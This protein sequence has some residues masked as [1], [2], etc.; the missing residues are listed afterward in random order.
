M[1]RTAAQLHAAAGDPLF[2]L[3]AT[4][5]EAVALAYRGEQAEAEA[6]ARR[7]RRD[8]DNIG[9]LSI[10]A[11][12]SYILGETIADVD[13]ATIAYDDSI[14][15]AC[16]ASAS[17]VSGLANTSL[18]AREVRAGRH[19]HARERLRAV[20]ETWLRAGIWNQQWLAIRILIEAL[21]RDHEHEAVATLVGAYAASA[22]AGPTYGTDAER[23][24]DATERARRQL[25]NEAFAEA[26]RRGAAMSDER[27]SAFA[28]SL[29]VA[30]AEQRGNDPGTGLPGA[31]RPR[32]RQEGAA[33]PRSATNMG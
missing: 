7:V 10:R 32:T 2:A 20:I 11:M 9:V 25:G 23:L 16:A 15:L 24:D 8:A 18:A 5:V 1:S 28:L 6:L 13:A 12:A 22:S 21:D 33:R 3:N 14:A 4:R 29:T 26:Q 30:P 27:A 17:F 31:R 19:T